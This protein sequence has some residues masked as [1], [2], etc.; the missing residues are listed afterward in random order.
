MKGRLNTMKMKSG[1][2]DNLCFDRNE[3]TK[4]AEDAFS[5]TIKKF[6]YTEDICVRG[7]TMGYDKDT[8]DILY[9]FYLYDICKWKNE[10]RERYFADAIKNWKDANFEIVEQRK[11]SGEEYFDVVSDS[12]L[13]RLKS[14][15]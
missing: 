14:L 12:L 15:I 7:Y 6:L 13:F 10:D 9:F 11:V 4:R 8:G 2:K 5:S 3:N 1:M